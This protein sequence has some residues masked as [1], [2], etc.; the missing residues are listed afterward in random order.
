MDFEAVGT[1]QAGY[2]HYIPISP[3]TLERKTQYFDLNQQYSQNPF[4]PQ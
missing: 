3:R 4:V 1:Y 2:V